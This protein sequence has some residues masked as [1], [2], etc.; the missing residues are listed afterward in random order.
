MKATEFTDRELVAMKNAIQYWIAHWDWE[1]PTLFG[2]DKS[3]FVKILE[4]WPHCIKAKDDA[5]VYAAQ[6]SFRELLLGASAVWPKEKIFDICGISYDNANKLLERL[7][8]QL[9]GV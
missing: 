3:D 5:A 6:R 9:P 7:S 2:L 8:A 4:S 1:C